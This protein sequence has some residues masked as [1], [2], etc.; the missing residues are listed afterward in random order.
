MFTL[1]TSTARMKP[2][3]QRSFL[4]YF[5]AIAILILSIF[6]ILACIREDDNQYT[7]C[8]KAF[9][10]GNNISNRRIHYPF[11]GKNR[12]Q[13]CGV[14]ND[15]NME[16]TCEGNVSKI[17]INSIKYRILKWYNTAQKLTVARDDYWSGICAVNVC[18]NHKNSTFDDNSLFQRDG[19]VSSQL[20]LLYNCDTNQSSSM[21]FSTTCNNIKVVYTLADPGSVTC[22]PTVI[23]EVPIMGNKVAGNATV[24][25][26][27]QAL[28]GGFDLKWTGNY[29]ECKGCVASGG[30]C[31]NNGGSEFR[32]FCKDGPYTTT[33]LSEKAPSSG[34]CK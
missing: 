4:F 15:P 22:T 17:T 9:K 2:L 6:D 31:G 25:S 19:D 30:T 3:F 23:V 16:L 18:D 10:C 7:N 20:N 21:I 11:W 5:Y 13:Y 32:C 14:S 24:N 34:K 33:C 8:K 26:I 12:E 29:E 28:Q 1:V 27:N